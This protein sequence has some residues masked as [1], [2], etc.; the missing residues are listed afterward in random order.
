[1]NAFSIGRKLSIICLALFL[2]ALVHA[3]PTSMPPAG[4]RFALV[5]GNAKYLRGPLE[6]PSNDA[7]V[8]GKVL[9]QLGFEVVVHYDLSRGKMNLELDE[10]AKR[11]K[12]ADAILVYFSGHG[13]QEK[14]K[15]FLL[16]VE[17]V[18]SDTK[19]VPE[20]AV[21]VDKAI[22]TIGNAR[23]NVNIF[24]LDA[25]RNTPG[26]D[27][28]TRNGQSGLVQLEPGKGTLIAF[29][30]SPGGVAADGKAGGNSVFTEALA[31][32]LADP[33]RAAEDVFKRVREM[34]VARTNRKQIP[35][36]NSGLTGDFV[37][38]RG[39]DVKIP[40]LLASVGQ[41]SNSTKL[42]DAN[43]GL[44]VATTKSKSRWPKQLTP[45]EWAQLDW[46]IDQRAKRVTLDDL[47]ELTGR[48]YDGDASAQVTLGDAYLIGVRSSGGWIRSNQDAMRWYRSA[49]LQGY[50]LAQVRIGEMFYESRG[51]ERNLAEARR[52]FELAVS[53]GLTRAKLNLA[54]LKM[55]G[56][57]KLPSSTDMLDLIHQLTPGQSPAK[58]N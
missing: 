54:Q 55:S 25:C 34:V 22:A 16:P 45:Q 23:A 48:A 50:P 20:N 43:A 32:T 30:T 47:S 57:G 35:W 53:Q 26:E 36:L 33:N 9:Q 49:A 6:N 8:M 27:G 29:S 39:V 19:P 15:N 13:V 11:G 24:V 5:I 37:F 12:D 10:L 58:S 42:R 7:F 21:S 28:L 56:E 1:M 18:L 40:L 38:N 52:W 14:G 17:T 41:S 3:Q 44:V 51:A 2:H 31:K 46:E 4:K